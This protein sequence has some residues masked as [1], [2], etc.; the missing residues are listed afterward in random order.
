MGT[1]LAHV[2]DLISF[3]KPNPGVTDVYNNCI[4]EHD[5]TT[6]NALPSI[7]LYAGGGISL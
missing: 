6:P 3:F 4:I 2:L 7:Q 5:T 1:G